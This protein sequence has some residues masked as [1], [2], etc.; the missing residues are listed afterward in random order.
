MAINTEREKIAHL[1]RRAGLGASKAEVDYYEK[2]GLTGA[3]DSLLNFDRV[4]EGFDVDVFKLAGQK[5]NLPPQIIG[6]WWTYRMLV[7]KR[8][9]QEKMTLFWHDHFACGADKVTAGPVVYQQNELFRKLCISDFK[10]ILLE[11]SKN[12]A[13]VLFLDTN[14]NVKGH[15]NENYAREIMELFSLGIGNYSEADILEAARAFT[16]WS[17]TRPRKK[18]DAEGDFTL[19]EFT[20][21]PRLHDEGEK[22]VLGKTGNFDGED[23]V[24][25]LVEHPACARYIC[26][27]LWE[28]FAYAKP[29]KPVV[30]ALVD[31]WTGN[32]GSIKAVLRRIF[33]S[34]SFY[35]PK[36]ERAL[37][38][39]PVDFTLGV[40]RALGVGSFGPV[41]N[42]TIQD[43]TGGR[44]VL[45]AVQAIGQAMNRMGMRLLYPPSVA[46]WDPGAAWINSATMLERMKLADVLF[47]S[48]QPAPAGKPGQQNRQ[49]RALARARVPAEQIFGADTYSTAEQI[50]DRLLTV[51]DAPMPP[52]KHKVLAE[53]VIAAGGPKAL[54]RPATAQVVVH[55]VAK[56]IFASPE[57]QF[58]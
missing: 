10:T 27:K 37:Y 30:D 21:R 9:L 56:L 35:S 13:M 8:P 57:F 45:A 2:M 5:G 1:L 12:P 34:Q 36:A 18:A 49:V 29:E 41:V 26:T 42:P 40:C 43:A 17:L 46:G 19:P 51:F 23:I 54:E 50:V 31:T 53:T 4:D 48:A 3:V 58:C 32:G 44:Q 16:G 6:A 20:K 55:D 14:T 11:V 33:T 24:N 39:N 7:T 28:W 15:A 47:G 25:I 22:T 52:E 38:K